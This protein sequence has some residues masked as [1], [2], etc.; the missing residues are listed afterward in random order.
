[1]DAA[2]NSPSLDNGKVLVRT[3]CLLDWIAGDSMP[4]ITAR[5]RGMGAASA[6]VR[7]LGKSAAWLLDTLAEVG[8]GGTAPAGVVE[9]LHGVALEARYGLPA[10]LA[11]L[12]RLSVHGVTR[13]HLLKLYRDQRGLDLFAPE[14][15]LDLDDGVFGGL[16]TPI[17]LARLRKAIVDD[18][19]ES[20]RLRQAG[21]HRRA[22][23]ID[24]PT[25]LVDDLYTTSGKGLERVA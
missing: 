11:P 16:L 9:Q 2:L 6:R 5:F 19:Q 22:E 24:L 10:A 21:Q 1:L 14:Q 3:K 23:A 12:A 18:M 13:G 17:Q 4:V 20:L 15:V 8:R 7:D 25:K